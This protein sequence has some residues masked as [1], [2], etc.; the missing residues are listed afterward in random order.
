VI[1]DLALGNEEGEGSLYVV[2]GHESGCNSLRPPALSGITQAVPVRVSSLDQ[3]LETCNVSSVDFMKLD[4]EGGE[5]SVLQGAQ[6]LLESAPRPVILAE[7]Q[8]IRTQPWGYQ[9]SEI[10]RHLSSK[11]YK[12]FSLTA[13][14]A[15]V[16]LDVCPETFDGNFVACP[17]ESESLLN[18]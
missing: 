10:I 7:V 2:Q 5:L 16:P 14:G 4:V 8:D 11:S 13:D 15:V 12:W 17:K 1:E 3:W 18:R 9:A 6:R